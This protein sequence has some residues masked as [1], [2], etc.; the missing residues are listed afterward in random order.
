MPRR[1]WLPLVA[2]IGLISAALAQQPIKTQSNAP[3]AAVANS[4]PQGQPQPTIPQTLQDGLNRISTALESAADKKETPEEKRRAEQD[5]NAQLVMATAAKKMFLVGVTETAITFIGVML[6]LAT[7][8]YTKRAATAARDAVNE[9]E[10]ATKTARDVGEAQI[11]AYLTCEGA[12]F[13]VD[14]NWLICHPKIKNYGQSPASKVKVKASLSSRL[15]EHQPLVPP[16]ITILES[17]EFEVGCAAIPAG[18]DVRTILIWT[19]ADLGGQHGMLISEESLFWIVGELSWTD[20]FDATHSSVFTL[21][22]GGDSVDEPAVSAAIR[23]GRL[24]ASNKDTQ[25]QK[26]S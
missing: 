13:E 7:M 16:K 5:L 12:T 14:E 9:A 11:R 25:H 22:P 17:K 21:G 6:V 20:V 26:K 3:G 18:G 8:I 4:A 1:Y 10:R 24:H 15:E 23:T 19:H 2:V